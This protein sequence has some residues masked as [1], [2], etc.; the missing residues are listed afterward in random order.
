VQHEGI[1][2]ELNGTI[3]DTSLAGKII[4]FLSS[5]LTLAPP[6]SSSTSAGS[7]PLLLELPF[8][9]GAL[10]LPHGSFEGGRLQVRYALRV[11]VRRSLA[12]RFYERTLWVEH[13]QD[14]GKDKIVADGTPVKVAK[15]EV[16]LD[17]MLS[18]RIELLDP[19]AYIWRGVVRGRLH[20]LLV[21]TPIVSADICLLRREYIPAPPTPVDQSTT[22]EQPVFA[23]PSSSEILARF[24]ILDGTVLR[25]DQVPFRFHLA[26][27]LDEHAVE[28]R[29]EEH[30]LY[31]IQYYL[32]FELQDRQDRKFYKAHEIIIK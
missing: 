30:G 22:Q 18:L 24:Q 5:T 14:I 27:C 9:F 23:A 29:R 1:D 28:T 31:A 2:I 10:S 16:G 26:S 7:D 13:Q 19:A 8:N 15:L 21:H 12:D 6:S 3:D 17:Q 20:F 25:G 32:F 4:S 11:C